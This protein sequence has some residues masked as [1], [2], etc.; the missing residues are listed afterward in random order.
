[1]SRPAFVAPP[2]SM[3][4]LAAVLVV[5]LAAAISDGVAADAGD[6]GPHAA[7]TRSATADG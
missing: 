5:A 2:A 4:A 1:M 3:I 7:P 6:A